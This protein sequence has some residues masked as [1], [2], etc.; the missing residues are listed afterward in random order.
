MKKPIKIMICLV[1]IVLITEG[2]VLS[3]NNS[4]I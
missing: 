3:N 1:G 4:D 2:F